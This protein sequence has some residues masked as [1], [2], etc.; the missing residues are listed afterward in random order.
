[1]LKL[2]D[3]NAWAWADLP[4]AFVMIA[5]VGI[6]FEVALRLPLRW[7]YRAGAALAAATAF[8]L[9]WGNLAVGFAGSEDN[10]INRIFFAVPALALAA[11]LAARFRPTASRSPW[12]A[13]AAAQLAA[14]LVA[15][16]VRPLHRPADRRLHRPVARRS[17]ALRPRVPPA[18]NRLNSTYWGKHEGPA[19]QR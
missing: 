8:L 6:A 3:P 9:T 4:F 16:S 11:S 1:M 7:T 18:P 14:G 15:Y 5:A 10:P 13:A 19:V 2:A 17:A 12:Q